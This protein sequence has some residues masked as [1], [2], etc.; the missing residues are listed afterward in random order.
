MKSEQTVLK[1][2]DYEI[3]FHHG[4]ELYLRVKNI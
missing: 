1:P 3:I 2:R 4:D